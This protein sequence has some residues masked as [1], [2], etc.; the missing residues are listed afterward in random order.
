MQTYTKL[1]NYKNFITFQKDLGIDFF[2][3]VQ[4]QMAAID[5]NVFNSIKTI[6]ALDSFVKKHSKLNGDLIIK[7]NKKT[8]A[9]LIVLT[10]NLET[11]V[12]GD[13]PFIGQS[14]SMF[15]KMFGAIDLSISKMFVLNF[16]F[17][18]QNKQHFYNENDDYEALE[19]IIFK[20]LEIIK[21]KF[22]VDMRSNDKIDFKFNKLRKNLEFTNIPNPETLIN[23]PTL[24]RKA[25][26]NLKRLREKIN[27]D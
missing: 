9:K 8:T 14:L 20:Y 18:Q 13:F 7:H 27:A 16:C 17:S 10:D 26:E 21:P 3:S 12:Q 11:L 4:E 2:T 6:K 19:L 5:L 1:E 22:I 25:W 23:Y 24:K 15:E